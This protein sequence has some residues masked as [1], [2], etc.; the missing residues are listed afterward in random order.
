MFLAI[1]EPPVVSSVEWWTLWVEAG[2]L[3][4]YCLDIQ[5]K[6]YSHDKKNFGASMWTVLFMLAI[7]LNF[8]ELV[9]TLLMSMKGYNIFRATRLFRPY[10]LIWK[11]RDLRKM[12]VA[13]AKSVPLILT[14]ALLIALYIILF[15]FAAFEIFQSDN[16]NFES[17][18]ISMRS[19]FVLITTA[20]FPDVMM[21]SYHHAG[22][23]AF[24][25]ITFIIFG[26]YFLMALIL[27]VVYHHFHNSSEKTEKRMRT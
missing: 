27:A 20:N 1:C 18:F 13:I 21:P 10:F 26:L 24:F 11:L 15:A 6:K 8:L 17:I 5:L 25:F 12:I 4:V 3:C 22:Y 14:V 19:L 2:I 16:P 23:S 7:G 9:V